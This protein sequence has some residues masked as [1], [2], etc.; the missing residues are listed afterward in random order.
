MNAKVYVETKTIKTKEGKEFVI[1]EILI[2]CGLNQP[3]AVKAAQTKNE[4]LLKW[5]VKNGK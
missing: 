3:I 1:E 4:E 2:D 5:V